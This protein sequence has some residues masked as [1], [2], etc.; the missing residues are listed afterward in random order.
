MRHITQE[1]DDREFF[2]HQTMR[3]KSDKEL[4][5][6]ISRCDDENERRIAAMVLSGREDDTAFSKAVEFCNSATPYIREEGAYILGQLGMLES[7][8]CEE[9]T[10]ILID[11]LANDP[12]E[13]VRTSAAHSLGHLR[14]PIAVPLLIRNSKAESAKVR[15]GVAAALGS[16]TGPDVVDALIALTTDPDDEVRNWATFG[17]GSLLETDTPEIRDALVARLAEDDAEIR[18]EALIGL[19]KRKDERVVNPL[20]L[21]L[22]G[23]FYGD[24]CLE[25]AEL[26]ADSRFYTHLLSLRE[27][28]DGEVEDRFV[29]TLDN[30]I[31]ACK[32]A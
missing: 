6:V 16:Y 32:P 4:C 14:N 25:A 11:L 15:Y 9:S 31:A 13:N 23:E 26:M 8:H 20:I 3:Q 5:E 24:W 17:L 22:S 2:L 19:A 1:Q 29:S 28:I 7:P 27:R 18:G 10:H 12:N 30:A 21:E